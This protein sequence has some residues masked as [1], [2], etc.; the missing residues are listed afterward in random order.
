PGSASRAL[1]AVLHN[2]TCQMSS[3]GRSRT[4]RSR[5]SEQEARKP[6]ETQP[7]YRLTRAMLAGGTAHAAVEDG[8]DPSKLLHEVNYLRVLL[9]ECRIAVDDVFSHLYRNGVSVDIVFQ[10]ERMRMRILR[11]EMLLN[12]WMARDDLHGMAHLTAELIDAN[13]NSQSVSHL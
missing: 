11:A 4:G 2:L 7:L 9:D 3:T 1:L 12:A 6:L 10:V 5:H 8:G 13:N